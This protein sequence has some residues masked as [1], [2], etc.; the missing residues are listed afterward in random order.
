MRWKIAVLGIVLTIL[1]GFVVDQRAVAESFV[2]IDLFYKNYRTTEGGRLIQNL[3]MY[4][5]PI[6]LG[7]NGNHTLTADG[8]GLIRGG[9]G[10][11]MPG[12]GQNITMADGY[13]MITQA[14]YGSQE[15]SGPQHV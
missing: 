15:Q 14:G 1:S 8:I 7:L 3:A 11:H 10:Y 9:F 6:M 5:S 12:D 13:M 4:G 2:S